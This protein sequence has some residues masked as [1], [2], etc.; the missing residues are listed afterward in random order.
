MCTVCTAAFQG[1]AAAE[2]VADVLFTLSQRTNGGC[3]DPPPTCI[4]GSQQGPREPAPPIQS[5]SAMRRVVEVREDAHRLGVLPN[6]KCQPI[7][8]CRLVLMFFKPKSFWE[9][10]SGQGFPV[11]P[12]RISC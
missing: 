5:V 7:N 12:P 9:Q 2:W 1:K 3:R 11:E 4:A 10:L 8:L 6:H